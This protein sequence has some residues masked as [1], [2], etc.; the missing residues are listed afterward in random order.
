METLKQ[1]FGVV[2]CAWNTAVSV[3]RSCERKIGDIFSGI[4]LYAIEIK[5][6]N[7]GRLLIKVKD[8]KNFHVTRGWS[9]AKK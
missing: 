2:R 3:H 7:H 4:R 1:F 8:G 6:D 5:R 9:D